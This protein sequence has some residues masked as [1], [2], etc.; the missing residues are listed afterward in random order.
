MSACLEECP[1]TTPPQ[2]YTKESKSTG[3]VFSLKYLRRNKE[4]NPKANVRKT[5][6]EFLT[7]ATPFCLLALLPYIHPQTRPIAK[8]SSN[9]LDRGNK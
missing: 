4:K 6:N 2:A 8:Q 5:Q 7:F 3:Q 9:P 1:D